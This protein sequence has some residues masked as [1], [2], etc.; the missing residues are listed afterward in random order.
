MASELFL[1]PRIDED[2]YFDGM[3]AY[4]LDP[5]TG[6]PLWPDRGV[7]AERPCDDMAE[8]DSFYKWDGSAWR[9]EKKPTSCAECVA[10]GPVS[11]QSQTTRCN[12]LRQLYQTLVEKDSEHF[13]IVRGDNLEW[14]VEAIPEKTEEE[15]YEEVCEAARSKR[16]ALISETDYLMT[17]DYPI[18][19]KTR[20]AVSAYRQALRDVPQQEGFPYTIVWPEKPVVTASA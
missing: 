4:M 13:R 18:D 14:I 8:A 10:L 12:E 17:S 11:H 19:D 3:V 15:K 7:K 20:Q 6:E 2:G 5:T 1:T 16:D 9:A